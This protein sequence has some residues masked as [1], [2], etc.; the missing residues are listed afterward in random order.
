MA[1]G[2]GKGM[3]AFFPD[4]ENSEDG[5]QELRTSELRAN[6]YQPRQHFYEEAIEELK[7]S[8]ATHGVLQPIIAR[9]SIK[10]YE[11]VA[12]ERRFRAAKAAGLSTVPVIVKELSDQQM[13]EF[14]LIENLQREDLNSIEE[15]KAYDRLINELQFTQDKLAKRLGK[16]RPYIANHVRLLQLPDKVQQYILADELSMGHGKALL[17]LKAKEKM[18]PL[19]EKVMKEKMNVRQLEQLVQQLNENVPRET[20]E[21][22]V[23]DIF[24]REKEESLTERFG[25]SVSITKNKNKGKIEIE[26][27]TEDDLERILQL[28]EKE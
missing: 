25:T 1:R 24:I 28:I 11:I 17:S 10:G 15:A 18:L 6:P 5:I 16:S 20:K 12:G 27:F 21:K 14:A 3:S 13:M 9:K 26:F 23:K 8:I 4:H 22:P 19:A 7:Q 2:L